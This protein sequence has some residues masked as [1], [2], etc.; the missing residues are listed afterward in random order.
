MNELD[1]R[2]LRQTDC[3]AQRFTTP[4]LVRYSLSGV[5]G[6]IASPESE[7]SFTID[8]VPGGPEGTSGRQH[9][10][11]VRQEG[12]R[13][14]AEPARLQVTAGDIVLWNAPDAAMAGY[15]VR[16]QGEGISV[17]S[18]SLRSGAVYTHSFGLPGRYGWVDANGSEVSGE[19]RV[20]EAE[21]R[22]EQDRSRWM[23][24]LSR[25]VLVTIRGTEVSPREV[26][27]VVGQTVF[28]A[29]EDAPG[30]TIT[31]ARLAP[32]AGTTEKETQRA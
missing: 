12:Q 17:N 32:P 28:F 8:V 14:I 7:D 29:V 15:A 20:A 16:G 25:G 22:R 3:F 23:E 27:I 26:E 21:V 18:A 4:G 24:V 2:F 1:S 11:S 10:V 31:D 6:G 30:I 19:I 13:L 9:Q 5:L